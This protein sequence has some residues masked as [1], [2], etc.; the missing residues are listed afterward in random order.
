MNIHPADVGPASYALIL[1]MPQ[2]RFKIAQNCWKSLKIIQNSLNKMARIRSKSLEN[3][4]K[5][6]EGR[7]V[8]R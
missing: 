7:M 2:N 5:V 3:I 4:L 1:K 6:V 8:L